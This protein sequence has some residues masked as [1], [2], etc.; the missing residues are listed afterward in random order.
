MND[1]PVSLLVG[2]SIVAAAVILLGAV[3][4]IGWLMG[5]SHRARGNREAA[6]NPGDVPSRAHVPA[7]LSR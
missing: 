6:P 1:Q 2:E 4:A 7:S 5:R 3:L